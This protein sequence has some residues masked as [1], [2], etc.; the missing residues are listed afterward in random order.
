M[1]LAY[2][3][4]RETARI[5]AEQERR[6]AEARSAL[7]AEQ[8]AAA[9]FAALPPHEREFELRRRRA[10]ALAEQ[11]ERNAAVTKDAVV[12]PA[13]NKAAAGPPENK[14]DGEKRRRA[15]KGQ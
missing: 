6:N 4:R 3:I 12:V 2:E 8:K 1:G 9:E 15:K 13:E 14:A 11:A 7:E 5:R 10:A